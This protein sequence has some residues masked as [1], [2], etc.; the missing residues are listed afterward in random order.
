MDLTDSP[1][2]T[3]TEECDQERDRR[4]RRMQL[5]ATGLLVAMAA[6]FL[7]ARRLNEEH[8]AW[9]F[10]EAFA[11]A[12]L[13][14]ALAEWF[15]V[16]ALFR[17][18]LGVPLWHTAII[19]NSKDNIARN[20]G[21]IVESH[22]VTVEAVVAR[23]R[24]F[25][26]ARRLGQWLCYRPN[27]Q[28]ASSVLRDAALRLLRQGN[29][30]ALRTAPH[31]ALVRQLSAYELRV[32][33]SQLLEQLLAERRHEEPL[34]WALREAVLWLESEAAG[35]RI[36]AL[37]D[38]ALKVDNPLLRKLARSGAER[39]R[40]S[41]KASFAAAL[42]DPGHPI[43]TSYEAYALEL[44]ARLR[45]DAAAVERL[46]AF[47]QGVR[48]SPQFKASVAGIWQELREG[49]Q[50]GLMNP[51]SR[52]PGVVAA[53][54]QDCG[55]RLDEDAALRE[56]IDEA[57][58]QAAAPLVHDSRGKVATFIQAQIDAWSQTEMSQRRP[59]PAV[60]P[61]QRHA[62]GRHPR[63]CDPSAVPSA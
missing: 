36:A 12:T 26:P 11:E 25:E 55:A 57:L 8:A 47:Q 32:P 58:A 22:F 3:L 52:L 40:V 54:L 13:V 42:N 10:V 51:E 50:Q 35:D 6:L 61:D 15:A 20:P 30:S 59:R 60:H 16:V 49:L 53:L 63:S 37:L 33:V 23:I 31:A 9:V 38:G 62:H 28:R 44:F 34:N 1:A 24:D 41:L 56:W 17:H 4:L 43:R 5:V 27:A 46:E 2:S 7:G 45:T 21:Q 29:D 48:A 14:G 18:P 19:P 39:L